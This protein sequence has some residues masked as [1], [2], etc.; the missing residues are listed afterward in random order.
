MRLYGKR[1]A[2]KCLGR[3]Q[4]KFTCRLPYVRPNRLKKGK[5]KN[6]KMRYVLLFCKNILIMLQYTP[7]TNYILCKYYLKNNMLL[8]FKNIVPFLK[9][10]LR[11]CVTQYITCFHFVERQNIYFHRNQ[12]SPCTTFFVQTR[13]TPIYGVI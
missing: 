4:S 10:L 3:S 6:R 13:L 11:L 12:K 9:N 1:F 7:S 8:I 2:H 5:Q